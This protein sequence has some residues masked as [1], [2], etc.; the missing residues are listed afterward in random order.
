MYGHWM[1]IVGHRDNVCMTRV[2]Q[3]GWMYY[4][5]TQIQHHHR[6]YWDDLDIPTRRL[7]A[8]WCDIA[9]RSYMLTTV[10]CETIDQTAR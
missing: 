8:T 2:F 7:L 10:F 5:G 3:Q 4:W 9:G 6:R 1:N